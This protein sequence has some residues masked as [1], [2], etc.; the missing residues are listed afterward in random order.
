MVL[1]M[2]LSGLVGHEGICTIAIGNG[3]YLAC[4]CSRQ[5]GGCGYRYLERK[6][7]ELK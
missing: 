6:D 2:D 7:G 3:P 4:D 1:L 5:V